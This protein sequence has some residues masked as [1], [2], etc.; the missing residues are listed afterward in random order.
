MLVLP[1]ELCGRILELGILSKTLNYK[2][3]CCL[4][5]T[6]R[7][8]YR[9]SAEDSHWSSLLF[10]DFPSSQNDTKFNKNDNNFKNNGASSFT[11]SSKTKILYKIR[12]VIS[13]LFL[14]LEFLKV[15]FLGFLYRFWSFGRNICVEKLRICLVLAVSKV[16]EMLMLSKNY[17]WWRKRYSCLVLYCSLS[18]VKNKKGYKRIQVFS[19]KPLIRN[20]SRHL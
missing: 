2:D 16:L 3:L 7:R 9:L 15:R 17:V 1:D 19:Y 12:Y 5:I 10:A 8:L 13:S 18:V 20:S 6:C 4:S 14:L 11:A